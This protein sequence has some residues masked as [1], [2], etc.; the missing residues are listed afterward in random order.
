[1]RCIDRFARC[2]GGSCHSSTYGCQNVASLP[3]LLTVASYAWV[4]ASR[5]SLSTKYSRTM[6]AC[7][8]SS[9]HKV[10][11]KTLAITSVDRMRHLLRESYL[12]PNHV[13]CDGDENIAVFMK[14]LTYRR[15]LQV[16]QSVNRM[17]GYDDKQQTMAW[18]RRPMLWRRRRL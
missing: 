2:I 12:M 6:L 11:V 8:R 16:R 4:R 9:S 10:Y 14:S 18:T 5:S 13:E 1:M 17:R 7:W 15:V 3:L